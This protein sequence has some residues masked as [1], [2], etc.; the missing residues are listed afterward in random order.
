MEGLCRV[1]QDQ[2]RL[3]KK[4]G[5]PFPLLYS[6]EAGIRYLR[7]NG[8]ENW[9]DIYT[10]FKLR[11][12]DCE[13]LA[14]H[15]VAELRENFNRQASAFV[16]YRRGP[17]GGFHYHALVMA[18]GPDG[19]RLEDPS[20]KLGMGWEEMFDGLGPQD[21]DTWVKRLDAIQKRV[22]VRKMRTMKEV[23]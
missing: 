2:I 3:Q 12:G 21:K 5:K 8:T 11:S 9:Q 6:P 13:D 19:W 17:D 23:G 16:T 4:L 18:K 1:N 15:R 14:C 20:R 22:S 7:E 10:N